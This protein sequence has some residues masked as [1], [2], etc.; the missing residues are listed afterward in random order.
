MAL[1]QVIKRSGGYGYDTHKRCTP[2]A[3]WKPFELTRCDSCGKMLRSHAR[4]FNSKTK[5]NS[6][7]QIDVKRY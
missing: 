5:A 3:K 2:C 6:K 7:F 4:N 1:I